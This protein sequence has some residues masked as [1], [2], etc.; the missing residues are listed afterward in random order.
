MLKEI[1]ETAEG[2]NTLSIPS[3]I[4]FTTIGCPMQTPQGSVGDNQ[5]R[6]NSSSMAPLGHLCDVGLRHSPYHHHQVTPCTQHAWTFCLKSPCVRSSYV[7]LCNCIHSRSS[8]TH[9]RCCPVPT[10]T[11]TS[12]YM[13]AHWVSMRAHCARWCPLPTRASVVRRLVILQPVLPATV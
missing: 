2:K 1:F 13:L 5:G 10:C 6:D 9:A 7:D 11:L 3:Q 4:I 8:H 12:A